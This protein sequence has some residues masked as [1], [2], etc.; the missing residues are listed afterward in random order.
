MTRIVPLG[1]GVR[2]DVQITGQREVLK[3]FPHS[4]PAA[5]AASWGAGF[6][7][8]SLEKAFRKTPC[9]RCRGV[10]VTQGDDRCRKPL[11]PEKAPGLR[12]AWV[13]RQ[14]PAWGA[15]DCGSAL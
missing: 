12:E 13:W 7:E 1:A 10:P 11:G 8:N 15:G 5:R 14:G 4:V 9:G 2:V 6:L 3:G